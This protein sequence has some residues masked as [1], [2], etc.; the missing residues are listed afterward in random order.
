MSQTVTQ[1]S[2]NQWGHPVN[3]HWR[4]LQQ[5]NEPASPCTVEW[6]CS[7]QMSSSPD[8]GLALIVVRSI[9]DPP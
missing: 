4:S 9:S 3:H 7:T 1:S 6:A 8:R 2:A 5:R